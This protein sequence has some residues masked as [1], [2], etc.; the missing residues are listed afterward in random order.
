MSPILNVVV[1]SFH[2]KRGCEVEYSNPKLDGKGEGGLPEE[3]AHL[4]SLALPD[5]VHNL[6]QDVI[7]F[8]L[9]SRTEPGKCVFGIS[10]YRQID[11]TE[12]IS[13]PEDVTRCSVQKSVCVISKIP[14]F[15]GLKAKLEVI[16]QAYFE[17][18]DF[19]QI[20]VLNQMYDNLHDM[21][22][23]QMSSE[24]NV[25]L[26]YHEISVQDLFIRFR[27]RALMLF[28]LV[29]LERKV[30]FFG[31]NGQTIGETML[32]LVSMFPNLLEEGLFYSSCTL[33]DVKDT[34]KTSKP[35]TST[36]DTEKFEVD[37]SENKESKEPAVEEIFVQEDIGSGWLKK[38]PIKKRDSFGF[39]LSI[40]TQNAYF[41]PYLSISFLDVLTTVRSCVV[42]ATNA[43]FAMKKG[44]F[45]VV[46]KFE[47]DGT[48]IHQHVEVLT[49]DLDR[50]LA[51]TTQDLRF[52][53]FILRHVEEQ[54]RSSTAGYD[55]GDEWIRTQMRDYLLSLVATARADLQT[56]VPQ[57]GLPFVTAWRHTRNYRIWLAETHKDLASVAPGH[58]FSEQLGVYD[59]YLRLDHAVHGVEGAS[60]VLEA[61]NTTGKNI[62]NTIGE[63][64][65]RVK[66][67]LANWWR[68]RGT[69]NQDGED[70]AEAQMDKH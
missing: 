21:F 48:T 69:A 45:D 64:G 43:L 1:V 58:F 61:V 28:K 36:A 44:I 13:R 10:C 8:S 40:F 65:S 42:G 60:K 5:G 37:Y 32:A 29:L 68:G 2:H 38:D 50:L 18:R 17:Q 63:T 52:A 23:E 51:L 33:Q 7:F 41:D 39:P 34:E 67:K 62:G 15:G 54:R 47:D 30:L 49:P 53:D 12:L 24:Q 26:A 27:H 46:V 25:G 57:F 66:N 3:W 14:L 9:P 56:S 31:S 16:T 11:S 19:G 4:P 22:N 35:S 20:D 6:K 55:G 59:M 70:A